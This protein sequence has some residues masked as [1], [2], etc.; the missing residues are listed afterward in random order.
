MATSNPSGTV[1]Q[2]GINGGAAL[3]T[4]TGVY[5]TVISRT[6]T[7]YDYL[8]NVLATFNMGTSLT[9]IY[10]FSADAWFQFTCVAVDNTG[11]WTTTV[12]F[13]SQGYYWDAY[14][15]QFNATACGCVGNNCNLEQSQLSLNAALRFNLAGLV[16]AASSN[17]CIIAANYFVN[18]SIIAQLG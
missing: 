2:S 13:V 6:L 4:D 1:Q 18:Q 17:S 3:Y 14:T 9:Q 7:V 5:N 15:A 10:T 11:T 16:G 8:G 12:Y